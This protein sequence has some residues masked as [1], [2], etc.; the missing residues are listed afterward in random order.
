MSKKWFFV[1]FVLFLFISVVVAVDWYPA[2]L[3]K[4]W[5][6]RSSGF[7]SGESQCLVS[8]AGSRSFDGLPEKFFSDTKPYCL[9]DS[10]FVLDYYC[11]NGRWSSR[12]KLVA[13]ELL[14]I[15]ESQS[16]NDFSLFC[17]SPEL[18]LNNLDY[19]VDGVPVVD[20]F[21]DCHPY[22]SID[23]FPCVNSVCV[24]R[25]SDGVAFGTSLN[26]A[27]DNN[28]KSFLRALDKPVDLCDSIS[29][30]GFGLCGEN[31]WYDAVNDL[32]I[33]LP[34]SYLGSRLPSASVDVEDKF[35]AGPFSS[36]DSFVDGLPAN[37]SF[38]SG[39]RLFDNLY[40]ARS[41]SKKVFA[42]LEKDKTEFAYDYL[43]IKM[44][45]MNNDDLCDLI[46][47]VDDDVFCVSSPDIMFV[48]HKTPEINSSLVNYWVDLTA[49]LR[50]S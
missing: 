38:F 27:V 46:N 3:K 2:V 5:H 22:G 29:G 26:I 36:I 30:S 11:D 43:G 41:G 13:S 40:F 32:I 33:V 7:C 8:S 45:G 31:V 48:A 34:E 28:D 42:F 20:F 4:G 9:N 14:K 21:R 24:L 6:E 16:P 18:A 49:K 17:S 10:Q 47:I 25:Y 23:A 19:A 1:V 39:S 44:E 50:L 35:F 15:A 12:S 37:L